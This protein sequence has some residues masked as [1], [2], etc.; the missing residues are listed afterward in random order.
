MLSTLSEVT[1]F[2]LGKSDIQMLRGVSLGVFLWFIIGCSGMESTSLPS[3]KS[4]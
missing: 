4:E 2:I 1:F 3:E